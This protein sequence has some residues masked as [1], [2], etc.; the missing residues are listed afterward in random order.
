MYCE[1]ADFLGGFHGQRCV[2]HTSTQ[3]ALMNAQ[4]KKPRGET[5]LLLNIIKDVG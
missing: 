2:L 5:Y 3:A 4:M 1:C